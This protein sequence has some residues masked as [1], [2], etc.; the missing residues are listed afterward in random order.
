MNSTPKRFG[1]AAG[2]GVS[3]NACSD[4][5]HGS[6]MVT[7]APRSTVRREMR[8][9]EF[10]R[11]I[12]HLIHLSVA[13]GRFRSRTAFVQELRAG[14]DGLH[15]RSEAIAVRRQL[16]LHA[17]DQRLVGELQRAVQSVGQQFPAEIVDEVLL[18]MLADVGF[19]RPRIRRPG[20]RPGKTALVSTGRPARSLVRVSPTGP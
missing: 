13:L 9:A 1:K 15:Q 8:W 16:G 14:D 12:G 7:P 20:C 18:A 3:A 17:L 19:A 6:A 4:S 2:D 11:S 5:S 10:V